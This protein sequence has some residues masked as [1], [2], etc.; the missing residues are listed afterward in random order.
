MPRPPRDTWASPPPANAVSDG[1]ARFQA[2]FTC[3]TGWGISPRP[4]SPD[5]G[6]AAVRLKWGE[7]RLRTLA[8]EMP[9]GK[10]AASL[11][12]AGRGRSLSAEY[13]QPGSRR[14]I[15]LER[16]FRLNAGQTLELRLRLA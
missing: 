13:S 14:L 15:T 2:A 16:S 11:R 8:L 3:A 12:V 5:G 7:L 10:R 6:D 1:A 4:G 9:E